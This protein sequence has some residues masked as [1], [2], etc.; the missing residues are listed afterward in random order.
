MYRKSVTAARQTGS[1]PPPVSKDPVLPVERPDR[2]FPPAQTAMD[3]C[4]DVLS[5]IVKMAVGP[6]LV[7][8]QKEL[9]SI[10]RKVEA[11]HYQR[12]LEVKE[13]VLQIWATSRRLVLLPGRLPLTASVLVS[14]LLT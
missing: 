5:A 11:N 7:S 12:V 8:I 2:E 6:N 10:M 9:V 1:S 14:R 13:S 4:R 3:L